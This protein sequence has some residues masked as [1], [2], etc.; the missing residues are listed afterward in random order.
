[1]IDGRDALKRAVRAAVLSAP[2]VDAYT[3]LSAHTLFSTVHNGI[4]ALFLDPALIHEAALH[5]L[6]P[7]EA[8]SRSARADAVFRALFAD[9]TPMSGAAQAA[10]LSLM[11]LKLDVS[12]RNLSAARRAWNDLDGPSRV[13]RVL[14]AANLSAVAV[15]VDLF[16]EQ[17]KPLSLFDERLRAAVCVDA[18]A[19]AEA[20]WPAL[21]AR[22][23]WSYDDVKALILRVAEKSGALSLVCEKRFPGPLFDRAREAAEALRIP[24]VVASEADTEASAESLTDRIAR[25]GLA[26]SPYQS[27]ARVLEQ[28][29]GLWAAARGRITAALIEAY[30]PLLKSGW[31]INEGEI[32]HDAERFLGG[33]GGGD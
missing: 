12:R 25:E 22:G 29:P 11:A 18:L 4:D 8:A 6:I 20:A 13:L 3:A 21:A 27:R 1:M 2:A 10:A 9:R 32:R 28:L 24:L 5:T 14:D 26:F 23:C 30:A 17:P 7:P 33:S 15:R 19:D 31:K 16:T